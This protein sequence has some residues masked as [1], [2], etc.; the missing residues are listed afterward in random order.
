M[1]AATPAEA[2]IALRLLLAE[3]TLNFALAALFN[4]LYAGITFVLYGLAVAISGQFPLWL[5]WVVLVA[6]AGSIVV[7][8]IQANV[9]QSMPLTRTFTIIFPPVITLWVVVIGVLLRRSTATQ[10]DAVPI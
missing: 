10:A 4:I 8:L 1:A 3:E 9:G 7:G 2:P 6:G 5:G